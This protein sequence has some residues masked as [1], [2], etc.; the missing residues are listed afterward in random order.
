MKIQNYWQVAK[1]SWSN[2]LVYRLNFVMW[3]VR[4]VVQLLSV[5]FLWLAI[6]G[7][8]ENA[9]GY[10][11]AEMLTY[12]ILIG[13]IRSLV[14]SSRSIDAQ[15]EISS[16]N[17]SNYLVKPVN[18]FN[19]WL[20]RD[21]ADK[22][23]NLVFAVGELGLLMMIFKPPIVFPGLIN[24]LVFVIVSLLAM[25]LYF[26]FSFLVS[27]TTLVLEFLAGGFFPLDILPRPIFLSLKY[28]PTSFMLHVPSQIYL[29]RMQGWEMITN[30]GMMVIWLV[31]LKKL[32][33]FVFNKGLKIYEAY[34]R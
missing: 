18:Y 30:M 28:L 17:L 1:V 20:T 4:V 8:T 32:T 16:G 5:Y 24:G 21:L 22:L 25:L 3:R 33:E 2:G 23:L 34:G 7:Q 13:L 19:Y 14:F 27:F 11:R 9:F 10:S 26:Y 15:E 6:F 31:V 12:I 29:G